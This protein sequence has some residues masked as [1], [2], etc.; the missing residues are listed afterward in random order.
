MLY[1]N[2]HVYHQ[3]IAMSTHVYNGS[4]NVQA[5]KGKKWY[6]KQQQNLQAA[7]THEQI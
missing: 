2:L 3:L 4:K 6:E 7:K 1:I 5:A